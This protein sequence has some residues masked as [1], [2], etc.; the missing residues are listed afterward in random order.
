MMIKSLLDYYGVVPLFIF[1]LV[2]IVQC[3][4]QQD[5]IRWGE[6]LRNDQTVKR[7]TARRQHRKTSHLVVVFEEIFWNHEHCYKNNYAPTLS[8]N[9][10][11]Y[12]AAEL[13]AKPINPLAISLVTGTCSDA[14]GP[15]RGLLYG[16]Y[17]KAATKRWSIEKQSIH[18]G[19]TENSIC[20]DHG[21]V[22][23]PGS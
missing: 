17:G 2:F 18:R 13:A 19:P 10:S 7:T 21:S 16:P 4:S 9:S 23:V 11:T 1:V 15:K 22:K 8:S 12:K 3:R 5:S 6:I 20:P 14:C